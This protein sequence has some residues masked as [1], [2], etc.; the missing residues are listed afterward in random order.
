MV[1]GKR[2]KVLVRVRVSL[3]MD[4]FVRVDVIDGATAYL[5]GLGL[6]LGFRVFWGVEGLGLWQ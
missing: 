5:H 6:G 2:I 4:S 1:K 3:A